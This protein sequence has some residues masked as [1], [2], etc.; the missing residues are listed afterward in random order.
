MDAPN[1]TEKDEAGGEPPRSTKLS[2]LPNRV[3][4]LPPGPV[5]SEFDPGRDCSLNASDMQ[6]S[7]DELNLVALPH[8][9]PP[10]S[11]AKRPNKS[12][13]WNWKPREG[14]VFPETTDDALQIIPGECSLL[15]RLIPETR[16]L[17]ASAAV[18]PHRR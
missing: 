17:R 14:Y 9:Q 8:W 12:I 7:F 13:V 16:Y 5:G 15:K 11:P 10:T 4:V 1:P 3:R 2:S 18:L 6:P